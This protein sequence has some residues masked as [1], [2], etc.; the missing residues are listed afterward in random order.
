MTCN[1]QCCC[2]PS[3]IDYMYFVINFNFIFTNTLNVYYVYEFAESWLDTCIQIIYACMR[4]TY[5]L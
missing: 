1:L 2:L 3:L 5:I 4:F